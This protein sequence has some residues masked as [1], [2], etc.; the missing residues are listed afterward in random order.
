MHTASPVF[1]TTRARLAATCRFK[2][3]LI[4]AR[5]NASS[6][7]GGQ[8][9]STA[10]RDMLSASSKNVAPTRGFPCQAALWLTCSIN[11]CLGR[12]TLKRS[13]NMQRLL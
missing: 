9:R 2:T 1:Y 3:S 12:K 4:L 7:I 10:S 5:A 8:F 6:V 13:S 11:W